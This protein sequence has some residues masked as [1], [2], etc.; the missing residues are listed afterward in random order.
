MIHAAQRNHPATN[1]INDMP[2]PD[3]T[4]SAFSGLSGVIRTPMTPLSP[5]NAVGEMSRE[6]RGYRQVWG[7]PPGVWVGAG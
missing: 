1:E 6:E 5:L 3:R 7:V 4:P 2:K